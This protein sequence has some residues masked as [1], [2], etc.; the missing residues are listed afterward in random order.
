MAHQHFYLEHSFFLFLSNLRFNVFFPSPENYVKIFLDTSWGWNY[1][2]VFSCVCIYENMKHNECPNK[3][4]DARSF[5]FIRISYSFRKLKNV[6]WSLCE[7]TKK[8]SAWE[9]SRLLPR[10]TVTMLIFQFYLTQFH[11]EISSTC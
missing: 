3:E 2:H 8:T 9:F 10:T 4:I 6:R 7:A 11:L 5:L 1:T